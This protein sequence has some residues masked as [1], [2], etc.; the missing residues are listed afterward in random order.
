MFSTRISA[1]APSACRLAAILAALPL[2]A[3]TLSAPLAGS[4]SPQDATCFAGNVAQ[5]DFGLE[6]AVDLLQKAMWGRRKDVK[7]AKGDALPVAKGNALPIVQ[8]L[9]AAA[10]GGGNGSH[11]LK[12]AWDPRN[13]C[14]F[15]DDRDGHI[16]PMVTDV[17]ADIATLHELG[18]AQTMSLRNCGKQGLPKLDSLIPHKN[19]DEKNRMAFWL[20]IA[21][22]LFAAFLIAW[23]IWSVASQPRKPEYK[24]VHKRKLNLANE[25][26]AWQ[27]GFLHWASLTWADDLMGRYGKC[28]SS[29]IDDSELV[30]DRMDLEFEPF[31]LMKE[32]WK[33]EVDRVGIEDASMLKCM[34]RVI[35]KKAMVGL[36]VA[37]IVETFMSNVGMVVALDAFLSHLEYLEREK[38]NHP[39]VSVSFL[40]ATVMI[41]VYIFGVPMIFRTATIIVHLLDGYYTNVCASGISSIVF[42]KAMSL[43]VGAAPPDPKEEKVEGYYEQNMRPNL[44][45]LLNVDIIECWAYLLKTIV[46]MFVQPLITI[47]LFVML[48]QKIKIAGFIGILYI[49]PCTACTIYG[50]SFNIRAWMRYQG[51]QDERL[52]WLTETIIHIRTIKSLAWEKMSFEKLHAVR[53]KELHQNQMCGIINGFVGAIG[54]TMPWGTMLLA[55]GVALY[56]QGFLEAYTIIIIQRIMGG[57]LHSMMSM[58]SGAHKFVTV[59]NSFKRIRKFLMEN[60]LP[61]NVLRPAPALAAP[62]APAVRVLGSFAYTKEKKPPTLADLDISIKQGEF[63]AVIGAVASGKSA[64]LQTLLGELHAR[65]DSYVE[66]PTPSSGRVA[67]CSQVPW[68]FEG[69]LRENV[70]MSRGFDKD[71][72]FKALYSAAL[73]QD[74]EILPGGDQVTIGSYGI[75]LSGGQRARVALARAAYQEDAQLVIIDDPFA[76]VDMPTGQHLCQELILGPLMQGKTKVVVMQPNPIRLKCADTVILLEGGRVA[77]HGPPGEVMGSQAFKELLA[78]NDRNQEFS[79]DGPV[80]QASMDGCQQ[81]GERTER[82]CEKKSVEV[83]QLLREQELQDHVTAST[84]FWWVRNA[85]YGNLVFFFSIMIVG[86]WVGLWEALAIARWVDAKVYHDVDD[87]HYIYY[88]ISVVMCNCVVIILMAYAGTRVMISAS[89]SLH[90]KVIKAILRAPVDKFFDKQPVGRLINRLSFDMRKVDDAILGTITLLLS[91]VIGFVVTESFILRVVP[92]KIAL[93]SIPVFAAS[94]FFIYV[95]RGTAV[96]LV[97]HS[98]F[99]LSSVQDLQAT[100]LSCCVSIR[101]NNMSDLFQSRFNHFS[102]SVIRCH[103]LIFHICACWVQSRVFLCFSALTCLFACGGLWANVPLGTLATVISQQYAQMSEFEGLSSGFTAFLNILNALQRLTKYFDS[104]QEAAEHKAGDIEVRSSAMVTRQQLVSLEVRTDQDSSILVCRK[105]GNPILK[106]AADGRSLLLCKGRSLADLAPGCKALQVLG[107]DYTLTGV[108]SAS[109][110]AHL[111]AQELSNPSAVLFLDFWHSKFSEGMRVQL[112]CLTA[113]YATEKNVLHGISVNI[114]PMMKMG[115]AGK[116]GCGKST[117]MLCLL[118]MLE[119]RSGRIL[120]NG[121]DASTLGLSALRHI[122]GLVPQDPTIFEGTIRSNIDP[123]NEFPDAKIWECLRS[124]QLLMWVRQQSAGINSPIAKEG[125]NMSFGQRQLL[126]MARMV[127]R[128]PP[129]LLL[130]ECTSALDPNTQHVV[131]ETILHEFPMTTVIAIAHRVETILDFDQ[132]TVFDAGHVAEQ[133]SIKDVLQIPKGIFAGMVSIAKPDAITAAKD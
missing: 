80:E 28:W 111:M 58:L 10:V 131:Q 93:I 33:Q 51:Y 73:L 128:Q 95:F 47:V 5:D 98:K 39:E 68:I 38:Y 91:F 16:L 85:G 37:I 20:M 18:L 35:G 17:R 86:R 75:R 44:V 66:A 77:A 94:F 100:V 69:T 81:G 21:W 42:Q 70:L 56:T 92:M 108:N 105:G 25:E 24:E 52:R 45:Q 27:R 22:C 78:K 117:T 48:I 76:S 118:R 14:L 114:G 46:Y 129:V 41:I 109:R 59:P 115:F 30:E 34:F 40:E 31:V 9:Q 89:T 67:Y 90:S 3:G 102:H 126:C 103:Y 32:Q 62:D 54:H 120:L 116:T 64:F 7:V 60:E 104:P 88:T 63:V 127:I 83:P 106:S 23:S 82:I 61:D 107:E 121:V 125:A 12:T 19:V 112:D 55:A 11:P 132:V 36:V 97:F 124:M 50:M 53:T 6:P 122:V 119:P 84:C 96:P 133:G 65:E 57:L 79:A 113:G 99:A 2:L 110:Q 49:I 8:G 101:G 13:G 71:R 72:Y 43:P 87:M 74:L 1:A 130:D 4:C 123:F 15:P 26:D 29:V